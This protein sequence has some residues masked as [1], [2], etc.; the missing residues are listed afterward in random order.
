MSL[1]VR[2]A[3][4]VVAGD[5]HAVLA[6][7][8]GLAGP[9]DGVSVEHAAAGQADEKVNILP[10]QGGGQRGSAVPRRP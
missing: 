10:G 2:P 6:G 7:T 3:G 1:G 4:V 5:G 9:G 8:A